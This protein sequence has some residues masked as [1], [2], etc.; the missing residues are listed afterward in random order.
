MWSVADLVHFNADYA[1]VWWSVSV[2]QLTPP[3]CRKKLAI[4][5]L[6]EQDVGSS[7]S[8]FIFY[9]WIYRC[10]C[11]A[12]VFG[13]S[14]SPPSSIDSDCICTH[15]MNVELLNCLSIGWCARV[16][17]FF[18]LIQSGFYVTLHSCGI[19]VVSLNGLSI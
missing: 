15:L 4:A 12:S 8:L 6:R 7:G 19:F 2:I 14:L 11:I 1:L 17:S 16:P 13:L 18:D 5:R 3:L 10:F 9:L